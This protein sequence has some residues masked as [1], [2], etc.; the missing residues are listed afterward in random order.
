MLRSSDTLFDAAS[1]SIRQARV[2]FGLYVR[3]VYSHT[4]F[5]S[6]VTHSA[7][8]GQIFIRGFIPIRQGLLFY[9]AWSKFVL[10]R[11]DSTYY[12]KL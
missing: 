10:D 3:K 1:C 11:R 12:T 4:A 2:N 5:L 6:Y 8:R 9:E 7:D